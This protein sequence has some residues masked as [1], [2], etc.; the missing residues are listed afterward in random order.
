M[1][2]FL[3]RDVDHAGTA[4]RI[5]VGERQIT[6]VVPKASR[7]CEQ[8]LGRGTV[9]AMS[10]PRTSTG[11]LPYDAIAHLRTDAVQFVEILTDHGFDHDV[12]SCP[13]WSMRD[14]AWHVGGTWNF[15]GRMVAEGVTSVD[16]VRA[17]QETPRPSDDFLV[18]WVMAA[19]TSLFSALAAAHPDQEVW[20][21]TGANRDARWV[22]RRMTQETSVHR[23]DASNAVGI[24][25]DIPVAVAA[26]GIDEYL[27]W[28]AGR[29]ATEDSRAVGGTVHLHCTDTGTSVSEGADDRSAVGGEWFVSELSPSGATFTCEHAKGDVAVRG[30]AADLQ[31]WL[32]KREAGPVDIIGDEAVAERFR[33]YTDLR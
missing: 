14:L 18:D 16:V 12:P 31:L 9:T 5:E 17:W 10:D 13:G 24:P 28:F 8:A 6:H 32:W 19:H 33:Y 4:E 15:W 3:R 29:G 1:R 23:W 11:P 20:T 25:Y 30:R 2:G 26:D 7:A 21:W 22:E 27:T